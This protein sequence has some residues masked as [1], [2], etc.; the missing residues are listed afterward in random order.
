MHAP[1][2]L[3]HGADANRRHGD[4]VA[5]LVRDQAASAFTEADAGER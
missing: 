5:R 3:E 4:I 2:E 1:A